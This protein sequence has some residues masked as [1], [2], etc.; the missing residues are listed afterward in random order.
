MYNTF[1]YKHFNFEQN[2]SKRSY[3]PCHCNA[4]SLNHS[5]QNLISAEL[6]GNSIAG[7]NLRK[8]R[9]TLIHLRKDTRVQRDLH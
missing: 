1:I 9:S 3:Y 8:G 7:N 5:C 4:T 2:I 6:L